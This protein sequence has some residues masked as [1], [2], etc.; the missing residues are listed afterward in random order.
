MR[1]R[2]A[3]PTYQPDL[4]SRAAI[5]DPYPH[6]TRLRELGP[7]VWLAKQRA[8]ALPRYAECKAALRDDDTFISGAGVALNPVANR[9]S[10][11]TTLNS[12]GDDHRRRRKLLAQHMTPKSLRTMR[13]AVD[14]QA[15][16]AVEKAMASGPVDGVELATALPMSVVPDLIG[17]PADGREHL[18]RWA[19]ATFDALGPLNGRTLRTSPASIEMMRYTRRLARDGD[20]RPESLGA[21]VLQAAEEGTLSHAECPAL[22]IDYLAP[23]L[24]TTISAISSALHLF[25][26]HPEQWQLL[27]SDPSLIPNAVNE[28]VRHQSPLR[29]FSRK[30]IRETELGG[31]TIPADARVVVIYSSANRDPREWED[32]D[33]FDIRRDA[34]RQ[35]GFG[36]GTHGCAGQGLA[37]LETQAMLQALTDRV[38]HI[39]VAGDPERAV[40]NIIHRFERLPLHLIPA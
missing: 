21:E 35:I 8:Y 19:A 23:S 39:E 24:D 13:D 9:L 31:T 37:R 26:T 18:L 10:R 20:L 6:Y 22:L 29:A 33:T 11:G 3:T 27:R 1:N 38:A 32:P 36:H 17:W 2:V 34:S 40:N 15:V 7:V 30:V 28:V 25:A 4:Y 5:L 12:D 16:A 14:R